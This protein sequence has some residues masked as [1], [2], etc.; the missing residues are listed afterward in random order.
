VPVPAL[1]GGRVPGG[2]VNGYEM[3]ALSREVRK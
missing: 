1:A 3:P 2:W